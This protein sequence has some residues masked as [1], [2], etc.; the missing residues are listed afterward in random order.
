[1]IALELRFE[2]NGAFSSSLLFACLV[3]KLCLVVFNAIGLAASTIVWSA[4][5]LPLGPLVGSMGLIE[6]WVVFMEC[7]VGVLVVEDSS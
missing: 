5:F 4:K 6:C 3:S 7:V 2:I 1:M